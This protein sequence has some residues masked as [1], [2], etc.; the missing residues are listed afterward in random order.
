[1][2]QNNTVKIAKQNVTSGKLDTRELPVRKFVGTGREQ[3]GECW[4]AWCH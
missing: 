2:S 1:M 3:G 4:G